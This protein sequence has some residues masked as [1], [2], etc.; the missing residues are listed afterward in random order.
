VQD[1]ALAFVEPRQV[2]LCP[3]LQPVQVTLKGSTAFWC[4]YPPKLF[5]HSPPSNVQGREYVMKGS[6]VDIRT[7]RS[8]SNYCDRQKRLD[9]GKVNLIYYQSNQIGIITIKTKNISSPT[10]P[11]FPDLNL[12]LIF[13]TSSTQVVQEDREWGLRSV[14]HMFSLPLLCSQGEEDSCFCPAPA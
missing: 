13:S 4:I 9:S 14:H 2:P 11:F 8:L 5:Y 7:G 12:L 10:F 6:Q 1:P 3:T